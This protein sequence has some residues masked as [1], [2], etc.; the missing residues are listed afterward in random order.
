MASQSNFLPLAQIS[1][2]LSREGTFNASAFPL[3]ATTP[4]NPLCAAS[5]D[6]MSGIVPDT[7]PI[8]TILL[9][10][11]ATSPSVFTSTKTT[12]REHYD[13]AR[14]RAGLQ[15]GCPLT[16]YHDVLLWNP[17]GEIME[18]SIR[19][20]AFWRSDGWVTPPSSTGCLTGVARRLLLERGI[21][22]EPSNRMAPL[23]TEG[24]VDGEWVLLF[25]AVRGAQ[26]GK[27]QLLNG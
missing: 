19:N 24:L 10:T 12:R 21:I 7:G 27:L 1:V 2:R 23:K 17:V 8:L 26:L 20:V 14:T 13:A 3:P 15:I 11:Q 22:N 25:N 6:P 9:D 4:W 5:F 18:T 16:E